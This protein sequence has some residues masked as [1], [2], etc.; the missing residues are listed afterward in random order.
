MDLNPN[1]NSF[2]TLTTVANRLL[3]VDNKKAPQIVGMAESSKNWEWDQE[4]AEQL[5]TSNQEILGLLD[6][7][8]P[9]GKLQ[10]PAPS[11]FDDE[12]PY[13]SDWHKIA[14]VTSIRSAVLYREG[15]ERDAFDLAF[16][17]VE[18]G[19]SI[20]TLNV[21]SFTIAGERQSR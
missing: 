9:P 8:L 14:V 18:L 13:L 4:L 21:Q 1:N 15:R 16:R 12:Y 19:H 11:S 17:V 5:L 20:E 3:W 6:Q 7:A 2:L 10:V